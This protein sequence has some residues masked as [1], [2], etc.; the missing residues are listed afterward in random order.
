M[1]NETI[2]DIKY[3]FLYVNNKWNIYYIKKNIT[4]NETIYDLK[5]INMYIWIFKL[6]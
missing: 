4:I 1:L 5:Y 2:Y 3:M 6:L